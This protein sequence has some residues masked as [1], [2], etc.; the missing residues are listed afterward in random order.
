MVHQI[1]KAYVGTK[2]YMQMFI[3]DLAIIAKNWKQPKYS[4]KDEYPQFVVCL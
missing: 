2:T 3:A 1:M 4:S